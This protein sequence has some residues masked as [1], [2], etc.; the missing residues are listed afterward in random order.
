MVEAEENETGRKVAMKII[1]K[2]KL[3]EFNVLQ[4]E[5]IR[6]IG[7]HQSLVGI[8]ETFQNDARIYII[9]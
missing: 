2:S 4:S 9:M 8:R 5:R 1:E 6:R 3:T 7:E